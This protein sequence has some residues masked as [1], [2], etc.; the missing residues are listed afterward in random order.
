MDAS[1]KNAGAAGDVTLRTVALDDKYQ[2]ASG[3]VYLNGTQAL[4][5]LPM[6]QRARRRRA[7]PEHRRLRHRLPRLTAGQR[8]PEFW[9][10]KKYLEAR[11]IRFQPG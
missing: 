6:L 2:L 7:G 4:V 5:R 8:R 3:R 9:R 10:A 1:Q 11:H